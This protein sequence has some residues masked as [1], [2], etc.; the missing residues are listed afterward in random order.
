MPFEKRDYIRFKFKV[1][2]NGDSN[3][4]Q[5]NFDELVKDV[6]GKLDEYSKKRNSYLK[7]DELNEVLDLFKA[8]FETK[9]LDGHEL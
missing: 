2:K 4:F 7:N 3:E 9:C 6:D 5:F 1:E 8:K